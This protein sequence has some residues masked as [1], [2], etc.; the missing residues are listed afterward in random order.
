MKQPFFYSIDIV[1][2]CNLVCPS[3]PQGN[4][5]F[6]LD[7]VF[8]EPSLLNAILAKAKSEARVFGVGLFN[9]GEP[10][11]HPNLA[12]MIK[13]VNSHKLLCYL[14]TNLNSSSNLK[15]V[16]A[17]APHHIRISCSGYSQSVYSKTHRQGD[18]LK[19]RENMLK[20]AD[21][22]H[23]D[24][25]VYMLWHQYK[26]NQHEQAVMEQFCKS[27]G[28]KFRTVPAYYMPLETVLDIWS[29]KEPLPSIDEN[30][31]TGL[32]THKILC[33][34][35]TMPC[36]NQTQEITID[37]LGQV[38]LCCGVYD[39]S[40]FTLCDYL[41]TSIERIQHIRFNHS[42]CD[43]CI[44]DGGHIYVTGHSYTDESLVRNLAKKVFPYVAPIVPKKVLAKL[45]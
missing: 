41:N 44:R 28:F 12:E 45:L 11:T 9:W 19:V 22:R 39:P 17:A 8:M 31:L 20:M 5:D 26:H 1:G 40:K 42:F 13:I 23:S 24:T 7:K 43:R 4:Q 15:K 3:C 36:R 33:Q 27:L 32:L 6:R 29:Y 35:R 37:A 18:I 30:L 2:R 25:Q 34:D 10:F 21:L 38:Q 14:S 16:M